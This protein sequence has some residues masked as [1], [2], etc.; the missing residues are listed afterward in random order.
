[1]KKLVFIL[2][3][4]SAATSV[5]ALPTDMLLHQAT[6]H[7]VKIHVELANGND[8]SGSGVVIAK[9]R[10]VTN[11]HVVANAASISV[12]AKGKS[13]PVSGIVPDWNH[14][15]CLVKVD[16]MEAPIVT[17]GS[18]KNLQY[19][20]PVFAIGYPNS[21]T[22]P[23]STSGY[24]KGLFQM[25]DSVIIRATSTFRLGESGGGVF[26]DAGH[27]VG[28]I[29]LKSPGR[30]VYYYNMPVE[31]VQALLDKPVVA[32][33][34]KASPAFWAGPADKWPFFMQVVHP[35]LNKNWASLLSVATRWTIEEPSNNEA[36]FYL[37]AAEY[38][39]HDTVSAETHLRQVTVANA[40]HSQAIYY[41]ALIAEESGK[42]ME[43]L[44][45]IALLTQLDADAATQLKS[46]INI[47]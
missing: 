4:L 45:N 20:Q 21:S 47:K 42:H 15:I 32:I 35:Y 40:Q 23:S 27:L 38:A 2:L 28:I 33:N 25:D 26:D 30:N 36:W 34:S 24:V 19:E 44:T 10:V 14:D 29:T 3:Y 37:A 5:K 1:M 22:V 8:G 11:C 39:I 16:D 18:S 7:V 43:A 31:W 17:I 9:D 12:T 6:Q 41:L 46:T 13:Y